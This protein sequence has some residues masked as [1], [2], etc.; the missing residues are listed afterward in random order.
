MMTVMIAIGVSTCPG[1]RSG[2]PFSKISKHR[3]FNLKD[4][5]VNGCRCENEGGV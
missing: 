1:N 4:V 5:I 3:V 2:G